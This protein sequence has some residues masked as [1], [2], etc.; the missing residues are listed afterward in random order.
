MSFN[1][2]FVIITV[3]F[4]EGNI[5]RKLF[6]QS[7]RRYFLEHRVCFLCVSGESGWPWSNSTAAQV[8]KQVTPILFIHLAKQRAGS[9]HMHLIKEIFMFVLPDSSNDTYLR[10]E[11]YNG[12]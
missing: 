11:R 9:T 10:G 4:K 3:F 6:G 5:W 1:H 2:I 7:V 12:I 8:Y